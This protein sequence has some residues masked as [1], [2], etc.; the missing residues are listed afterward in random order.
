MKI[1]KKAGSHWTASSRGRRKVKIDNFEIQIPQHASFFVELD[2]SKP[3]SLQRNFLVVVLAQRNWVGFVVSNSPPTGF[4]QIC[5]LNLE[6]TF[7]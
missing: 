4:R 3:A 1:A 2:L 6:A 5:D 7:L